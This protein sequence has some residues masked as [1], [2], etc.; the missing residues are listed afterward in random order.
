MRND[1]SGLIAIIIFRSWSAR[2][3]LT[4]KRAGLLLCAF[5]LL[6]PPPLLPFPPFPFPRF[7]LSLFTLRFAAA[8]FF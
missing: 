3:I 4:A 2:P 7:N 8:T 1:P 5:L 6:L